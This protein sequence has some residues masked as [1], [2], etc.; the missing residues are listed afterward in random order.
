MQLLRVQVWSL[1]QECRREGSRQRSSYPWWLQFVHSHPSQVQVSHAQS[2]PHLV[3][4]QLPA[5]E[6][7]MVESVC[8]SVV[9]AYHYPVRQEGTLETPRQQAL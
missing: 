7:G 2:G 9:M 5:C 1:M 6:E 8:V 4:S 3:H